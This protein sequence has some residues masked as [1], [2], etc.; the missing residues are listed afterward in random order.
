MFL[1]TILASSGTPPSRRKKGLEVPILHLLSLYIDYYTE[2]LFSKR[3][4]FS[5]YGGV[6]QGLNSRSKQI[7]RVLQNKGCESAQRS[8]LLRGYPRF[9]RRL[10]SACVT[11]GAMEQTPSSSPP[12]PAA[13]VN[14]D[15]AQLAALGSQ[16]RKDPE[17]EAH[18]KWMMTNDLQGKMP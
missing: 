6:P 18:L 8:R 1:I 11:L 15:R 5:S 12:P 4:S 14:V 10:L 16:L 3:L 7:S 17:A 9:W 13:E 2:H